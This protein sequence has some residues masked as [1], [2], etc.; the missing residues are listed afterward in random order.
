M[1]LGVCR[2]SQSM[3]KYAASLIWDLHILS[4]HFIMLMVHGQVRVHAALSQVAW[5]RD[6]SSVGPRRGFRG[7]ELSPMP[8]DTFRTAQNSLNMFACD[9]HHARLILLSL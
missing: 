5:R 8:F 2:N 7:G 3:F 6:V 9:P 1:T 4:V